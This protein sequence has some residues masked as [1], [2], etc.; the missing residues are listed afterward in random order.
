MSSSLRNTSKLMDAA[1]HILQCRILK[2]HLN[3]EYLQVEGHVLTSLFWLMF[4]SIMCEERV[5]KSVFAML[6]FCSYFLV[7]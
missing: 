6:F 3:R 5:D 4:E 2:K 1:S 7:C